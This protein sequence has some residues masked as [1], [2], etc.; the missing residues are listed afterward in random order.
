M[1]VELFVDEMMEMHLLERDF[2]PCASARVT[3]SPCLYAF[4]IIPPNDTYDLLYYIID[5]TNLWL[6]LHFLTVTNFSV[7][8]HNKFSHIIALG[9]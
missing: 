4:S 9:V 2:V 1:V 6:I 5:I 8:S 3:Q 7:Q